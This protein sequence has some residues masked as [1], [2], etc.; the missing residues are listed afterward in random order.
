MDTT[1]ID[2]K[3]QWVENNKDHLRDYNRQYKLKKRLEGDSD[4]IMSEINK[5]ES[6]LKVLRQILNEANDSRRVLDNLNNNKCIITN[7]NDN[8]KYMLVVITSDTCRHSLELKSWWNLCEANIIN[9]YP[10]IAICKI[11][12]DSILPDRHMEGF[13]NYFKFIMSWSPM[14]VMMSKEKWQNPETCNRKISVFNGI[15]ENGPRVKFDGKQSYERTPEGIKS[16]INDL[17]TPKI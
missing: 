16:W 15:V 14:I 12:V 5:R 2:I 10:E 6:D 3:K 8:T 11:N 17:L 1:I 7:D 13:P 9:S 4:K